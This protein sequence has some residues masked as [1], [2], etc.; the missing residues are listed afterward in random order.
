MSIKTKNAVLRAK[1]EATAGTYEGPGSGDEILIEGRPGISFNPTV[2]Q[3]DETGGSFDPQDDIIG[4]MTAQVTFEVWL[5]GTGTAGTAPEWGTLIQAAGWTEMVNASALPASAEACADGGTANLAVMGS[6]ATATAQ[7]YRGMPVVLTGT[8]VGATQVLDYTASKA[9]TLATVLS[10]SVA[11]TSNWQIPAHVLYKPAAIG[12]EKSLSM[13]IFM[14]GLRYQFRGMRGNV[15]IEA[16]S[17]GA[18]KLQFTLTGLLVAK[19]DAAVPS[20]TFDTTRPPI[21]K[22]GA[23]LINGARAAIQTLSIDT[24]A[25]IVNADDPNETDGFAAT[26][27]ISRRTTGSINP[28][29]V[30]VATRD[31]MA[32]FRTGAKRSV[33]AAWGVTAGNRIMLA[34]PAAKYLNLTPEDRNGQAATTLPFQ[35]TGSDAGAFLAI[36]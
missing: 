11:S 30:L 5:K 22:G 7:A 16:T 28:L 33:H 8:V 35:A 14:D 25:E 20:T 1:I 23:A 3:T 27:M 34:V 9:A 4:S 29:E 18:G 17:G 19:T 31:A 13:D 32:D 2:V 36:W 6:S 10:G 15:T 26:E 24:G 21:W 12:T